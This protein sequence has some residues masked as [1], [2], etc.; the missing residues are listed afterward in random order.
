MENVSLQELR[1]LIAE[2]V[3]QQLIKFNPQ[4]QPKTEYLTRIEVARAL[5]ISLPTLNELTKT[6][7]IPAYR[8]GGRVLYKSN[9]VRES[10]SKIKVLMRRAE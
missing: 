8:I 7:K 3:S 5:R 4:A 10:L 2:V 6:G 9:E 1:S